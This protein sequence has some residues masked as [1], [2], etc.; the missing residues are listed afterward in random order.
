[1]VGKIERARRLRDDVDSLIRVGSLP[2]CPY[3]REECSNPERGC[4]VV[5]FGVVA[6]DGNVE[7]AWRCPRMKV[8]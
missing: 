6:S 4:E 7:D 5:L 1:M 8:S 2:I 3:D